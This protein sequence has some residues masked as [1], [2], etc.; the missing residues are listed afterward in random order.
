M[1]EIKKKGL[2]FVD[3]EPRELKLA[4]RSVSSLLGISIL[5][6][7]FSEN[8]VINNWKLIVK[9][10]PRIFKV[11]SEV[12]KKINNNHKFSEKEIV[13]YRFRII[14][15]ESFLSVTQRFGFNSNNDRRYS[16][17][18]NILKTLRSMDKHKTSW[19]EFCVKAKTGV[20]YYSDEILNE[21]L[22]IYN[23]TE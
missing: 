2:K 9:K 11:Y 1:V 14:V 16:K 10:Y 20:F 4:I 5:P 3:I 8:E 22:E 21:A 15:P 12:I 23:K 18:I 17:M 6:K 13:E 7:E 19:V